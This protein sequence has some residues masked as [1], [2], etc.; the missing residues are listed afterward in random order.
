M[1]QKVHEFLNQAEAAR[2]VRA[3]VHTA[4]VPSRRSDRPGVLRSAISIVKG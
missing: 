3:D 2:S 4:W 1:C